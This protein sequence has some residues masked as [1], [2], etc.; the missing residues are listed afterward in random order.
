MEYIPLSFVAFD[1]MSYL[2]IYKYGSNTFR[3]TYIDEIYIDYD[4]LLSID[5]CQLEYVLYLYC[6]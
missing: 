2:H 6:I 1:Y 3:P 4:G 5:R